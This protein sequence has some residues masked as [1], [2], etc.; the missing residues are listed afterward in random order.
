M[1]VGA[2]YLEETTQNGDAII[3]SDAVRVVK[4]TFLRSVEKD[5]L[6]GAFKE[7]FEK[8]PR[9]KR[10]RLQP[11]WKNWQRFSPTQKKDR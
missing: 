10:R 9:T 7:G 3:K 1:Y 8:T 2:L 11:I 6:I 5:K 4:L